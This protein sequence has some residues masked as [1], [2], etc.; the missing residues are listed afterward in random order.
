MMITNRK[1]IMH[2]NLKENKKHYGMTRIKSNVLIRV[3]QVY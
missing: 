2:L 3:S 1:E